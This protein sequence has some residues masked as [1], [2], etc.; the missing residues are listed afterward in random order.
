M[1]TYS[2]SARTAPLASLCLLCACGDDRADPHGSGAGAL[3]ATLSPSTQHDAAVPDKP[4]ACV[5]GSEQACTCADGSAGSRSCNGGVPS[6]TCEGCPPEVV[7]DT[8]TKCVPGRY[9]G[10]LDIP[11]Y[12]PGPAGVCGLFTIFGGGGMGSMAFTLGASDNVEFATV[13]GSSSCLDIAV[14]GQNNP[15]VPLPEAGVETLPDGG[16]QRTL[17]MELSGSVD[18]RTGKFTGEVKGTYR[19]VSFC[20]FGMTENDYFMKG[21]VSAM[22]DPVTRSFVDGTVDLKEPPVVL[23]LGGEPGGKGSWKAKLDLA[24]VTP[25]APAGGCLKGVVFRDDLFP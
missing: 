21:P 6:T 23:P 25:P 8:S 5:S 24:A 20:D 10:V 19:S 1:R 18:C 13:V 16:V 3:D 2:R 15:D 9:V 17:S 11:Y 4:A 7:I 14:V 22:F 12:A